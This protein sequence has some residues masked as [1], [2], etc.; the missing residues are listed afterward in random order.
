PSLLPS[1]LRPA[2]D[3]ARPPPR[4][5]RLPRG[6]AGEAVGP[7]AALRPALEGRLRPRAGPRPGAHRRGCDRG[8][9]P[10]ARCRER[11]A[12]S[13]RRLGPG[14]AEVWLRLADEL[15]PSRP[16]PGRRL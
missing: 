10:P 12:R 9:L 4:R 16:V 6:R 11:P 8:A 2:H 5:A 1:L 13:A 14:D 3:R 7:L 15:A